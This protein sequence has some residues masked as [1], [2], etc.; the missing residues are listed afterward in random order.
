MQILSFYHNRKNAAPYEQSTYTLTN[1]NAEHENK[2]IPPDHH[3][4]LINPISSN[5]A[6]R[7]NISFLLRV[8]VHGIIPFPA[9]ELATGTQPTIPTKPRKGLPQ[10]PNQE[11]GT[12]TT[13]F[14]Q[15]RSVSHGGDFWKSRKKTHGSS[16][17]LVSLGAKKNAGRGRMREPGTNSHLEGKSGAVVRTK[18]PVNS[19]CSVIVSRPADKSLTDRKYLSLRQGCQNPPR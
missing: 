11:N 15:A 12:E 4:L 18:A 3:R 1:C 2:K 19:L 10:R 17:N 14:Q 9:I 7:V 13:E 8:T 16:S 6:F 5:T